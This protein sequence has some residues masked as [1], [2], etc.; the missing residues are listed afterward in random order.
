LTIL[1]P[2]IN[3]STWAYTGMGKTV[4][5]GFMQIKGLQEELIK[6][7]VTERE[8]HGCYRSLSDVLARL[9]PDLPQATLLIKA[10][11]LDSIAGELTRPALLWR[12]VASQSTK[13]PR[14]IPIPAEYSP[15]EETLSRIRPLW[16]PLTLSSARPV[17]GCTRGDFAHSGKGLGSICGQGRDPHGLVAHRENRI[18]EER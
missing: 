9:K 12:T 8:E 13:P 7:L 5:V 11:C 18:H 6:R 16:L 2:D 15:A 3:A 1:P 10:G 14:Y 4:R 17:Q